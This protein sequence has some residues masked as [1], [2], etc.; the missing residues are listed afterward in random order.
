[1]LH[2]EKW[3]QYQCL[4]FFSTSGNFNIQSHKPLSLFQSIKSLSQVQTDDIRRSRKASAPLGTPTRNPS[5]KSEDPSEVFEDQ[6]LSMEEAEMMIAQADAIEEKE[7]ANNSDEQREEFQRQF[8]Q[9]MSTS[10]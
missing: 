3:T 6:D 5:T 4:G 10:G 1:M 2:E 7:N 8:A 9:I